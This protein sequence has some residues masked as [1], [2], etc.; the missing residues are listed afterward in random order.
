M[1]GRP[2]SLDYLTT[3]LQPPYMEQ[4]LDELDDKLGKLDGGEKYQ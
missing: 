1:N 3:R 4:E 2:A